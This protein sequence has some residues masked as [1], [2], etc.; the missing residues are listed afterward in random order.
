MN[1]DRSL[2]EGREW[3]RGWVEVGGAKLLPGEALSRVRSNPLAATAFGGEFSLSWDGCTARDRLG[4]VPGGGPAGKITCRGDTIGEVNPQYPRMDLETAIRE[5][6][7]LRADEGVVALSG[8]VDSS[9]VA[10]LAGLPCL[11]VGVEGSHDL[12]K[13]DSAARLLGLHCT[14][15]AIHP[16]EVE[17]ALAAVMSV[18]PQKNA[19]DAAIGTTV[20]FIT[21]AARDMGAFR[22]LTGQGADELFGGYARYLTT[23]DI[24][25]Q[26]ATDFATLG[27][28]AERD[29]AVAALHG[30][31]LSLPYL[32]LRVVD[33]AKALPPERK[34]AGG[35]RKVALREVA[36][37]YMPRDLAWREK[38]AM[39]YG[40]GV[41]KEIRRLSRSKGYPRTGDYLAHLAGE[42]T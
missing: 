26:L 32:D 33:A 3:V 8:G 16:G 5:A 40:S 19:V 17:E 29:Q 25:S 18:I 34:V 9:L 35:L 12:E 24:E 38:K 27:A 39:Q 13:A 1:I 10:V 31:L 41:A 21:R 37:R 22:V 28:Q 42:R 15:V 30:V 4:I 11:A 14:R 20:F 23:G 6:V 7:R 36:G 2:S